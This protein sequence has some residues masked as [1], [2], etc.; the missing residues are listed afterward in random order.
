MGKGKFDQG[1]QYCGVLF[2]A[3][4]PP[5]LMTAMFDKVHLRVAGGVLTCVLL[6]HALLLGLWPQAPGPGRTHGGTRPMQARQ[7][8]QVN[9]SQRP[10]ALPTQ[11]RWLAPA[12]AAA[13]AAQ[14]RAAAKRVL[15]PPSVAAP[16]PSPSPSS[17]PSPT[18]SADIGTEPAPAVTGTRESD[19]GGDS[20][21]VF[22]TQLPPSFSLQYSMRRGLISAQAELRWQVSEQRY[23]LSLQASAFNAKP[24][25]WSSVGVIDAHGLAPERFTEGRRGREQRAVNFQRDGD[26]ASRRVIFS[27]PQLQL[28]LVPGM[29]DRMSWMLQLSAIVAANPALAQI[30]AQVPM[31]VVGARGDAEVWTFTVMAIENLDL[32]AGALAGALHLRREPRRAYDAQTDVWLDPARHHLPV[33]ARLLVRASGEGTDFV[34]ESLSLP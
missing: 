28:P 27:G 1:W 8:H 24:M 19:P 31:F 2:A 11:P 3:K 16:S 4:N 13:P 21:P 22:A 26:G 23:A 29:Q 25:V 30:G 14:A 20:V 18:P 6:A 34:M 12:P 15:P 32:P 9:I 10:A 17:T 33:R 5:V 7:I